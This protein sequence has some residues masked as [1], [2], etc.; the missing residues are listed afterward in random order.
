MPA[1]IIWLIIIFLIYSRSKGKEQ[2]KN[3]QYQKSYQAQTNVNAYAE[4]K[5]AETLKKQQELKNRLQQK[6]G[7]TV[8]ETQTG[9]IQQTRPTD[10]ASRVATNV[11]EYEVDELKRKQ[12]AEITKE[13]ILHASDMGDASTDT[14]TSEVMNQINDL[15]I[16][17]YQANLSFERD[18]IGEG[19]D[20]LSQYE[21]LKK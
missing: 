2:K 9:S 1:L 20:L 17:G 16:M 12:S 14:R 21:L 5:N 7:S 3:Q 19:M 18:F 15:M 10:I 13:S 8:T 11:K 4:E 6:Y